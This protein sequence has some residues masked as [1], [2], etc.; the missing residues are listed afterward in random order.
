MILETDNDA[1][2]GMDP[3]GSI[4]AWNRQAELTFGWPAAEVLGRR[5]CDTVVAPEYREAHA[6][7]VEHFLTTQG[8]PFN[9]AIE[10]VALHR[11]GREFPVEA[12]VWPVQVGG[13]CSF[14]AFIR[15]ISE[16]RRAEEARKKE[17]R[18]VQ[19]LQAVTVAA[20]RSS[21]IEHTAKTCLDLI[22][23]FTGWPVGHA[24][25]RANNSP[26]ELIP[27]GLWHI[28][29][30]GRFTAFREASD[31]LPFAFLTGL[32]G[33]VLSTVKPRCIVN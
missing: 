16:R 4:T 1:F 18:L 11:D 12:T 10:L 28:E 3:D 25:V 26:E 24:Y 30:D 22:C 13:A 32:P 31:R 8:S 19:L 9:R 29:E 7:G 6:H 21:S 27:M 17:A 2:I 15:D 23:S 33:C 20:N 14:N 5:L